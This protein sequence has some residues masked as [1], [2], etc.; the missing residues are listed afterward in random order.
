MSRNTRW[1]LLVGIALTTSLW[2]DSYNLRR[3]C[4]E[5]TNDISVLLTLPTFVVYTA[6]E[7]LL[8]LSK[9]PAANNLRFPSFNT[10]DSN[11]ITGQNFNSMN[12]WRF[13]N[14]L[15]TG[16]LMAPHRTEPSWVIPKNITC[17]SRYI[18]YL[19]HVSK[20][21]IF[22]PDTKLNRCKM[23][24]LLKMRSKRGLVRQH[25]TKA[26]GN[27]HYVPWWLIDLN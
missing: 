17:I 26:K 12:L 6:S 11:A 18:G 23:V 2:I 24:A 16:V 27:I 21:D 1:S 3:Q 14:L 8:R 9:V 10:I 22:R 15:S 7:Y 25:W 19:L 5:Q 13:W 4:T 20:T